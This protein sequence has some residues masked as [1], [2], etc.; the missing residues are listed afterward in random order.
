MRTTTLTFNLKM[1][2]VEFL[3]QCGNATKAQENLEF[4][5]VKFEWPGNFL[6]TKEEQEKSSIIDCAV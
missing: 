4:S 5:H 1:E 3:K 6:R 2:A